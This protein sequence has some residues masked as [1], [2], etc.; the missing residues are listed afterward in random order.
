[1]IN[2]TAGISPFQQVA[3]ALR[4]QITVSVLSPGDRLPSTRE[5]AREYDVALP[6]A[7]RAVE[8]LRREGLIE[9]RRGKGSFVRRRPELIRFGLGRYR[10]GDGTSPLTTESLVSGWNAHIEGSVRTTAADLELATRLHVRVGERLSLAE[11]R[12]IGE[13]DQPVQIS[14]Q[15]EPLSLTGGTSAEVPPTNGTPD[16][17]SRFDSIGIRIDRV[18][19]QTRTRM[20]TAT[21]AERLRITS[22]VPVFVINRTHW[23]GATATETAR[24]IIRGD[25]I[26]IMSTHIVPNTESR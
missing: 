26:V 15:W 1:M 23:A 3:A 17:I 6:T 24:I 2:D 11:Y 16:V 25:K 18:D 14:T 7:Q 22:L 5:L 9:T 10:R 8:E 20:P 21:E 4:D 19:E 13:D 12:W